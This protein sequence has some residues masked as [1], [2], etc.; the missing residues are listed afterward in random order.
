MSSVEGGSGVTLDHPPQSNTPNNTATSSSSSS[1]N[2][3][4]NHDIFRVD[5]SISG[6]SAISSTLNTA[7]AKRNQAPKFNVNLPQIDNNNNN[8]N[9]GKKSQADEHHQHQPKQIDKMVVNN[10]EEGEIMKNMR[11]GK[12]E[13]EILRLTTQ[14]DE[15][16]LKEMELHQDKDKL[17]KLVEHF[18]KNNQ[19]E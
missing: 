8:N 18:K 2:N 4:N 7:A 15:H 9:N 3:N 16:K 11:N 6:G 1:N 14:L 12:L 5:G 17:N 13:T 10:N 19:V